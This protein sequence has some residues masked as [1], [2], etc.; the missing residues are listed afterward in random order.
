MNTELTNE[1][2]NASGS[3][4]ITVAFEKSKRQ[5]TINSY[6]EIKELINRNNLNI[7]KD[8]FISK[9][10]RNRTYNFEDE[11]NNTLNLSG[12]WVSGWNEENSTPV[13]GGGSSVVVSA[14]YEVFDIDGLY[15]LFIYD[16]YGECK[17]IEEV[18]ILQLFAT[19][20]FEDY[21]ESIKYNGVEQY[22]YVKL[23]DNR[24]YKLIYDNER[25]ITNISEL[26][27][28]E[29]E[30]TD[31]DLM[32]GNTTGLGIAVGDTKNIK[33]EIILIDFFEDFQCSSNNSE[34]VQ[35]DSE[36]NITG[37]SEGETKIILTGKKSGKSKEFD[38]SVF[39]E[40]SGK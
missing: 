12:I 1:G 10:Y 3:N 26:S 32:N 17:N 11:I 7:L 15:Y 16:N 9:N 40:D 22:E 29:N 34:V 38:I 33:D 8:Y 31:M 13:E 36:G 4:P 6:G 25:N 18:S 2:A 30:V 14:S 37:I 35:I 19:K 28:N 21:S 20:R 39:N 23:Y 5:Y 27:N 24:Y